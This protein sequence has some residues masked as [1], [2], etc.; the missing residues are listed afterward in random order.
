MA[1]DVPGL[2][3]PTLDPGPTPACASHP[4]EQTLYKG[5]AQGHRET[6]LKA[7]SGDPGPSLSSWPLGTRETP[8]RESWQ[9]RQRCGNPRVWTGKWGEVW[10]AE[11][12]TKARGQGSEGTRPRRPRWWHG[13]GQKEVTER[14]PSPCG[15]KARAGPPGMGGQTPS[16]SRGTNGDPGHKTPGEFDFFKKRQGQRDAALPFKMLIWRVSCLWEQSEDLQGKTLYEGRQNH[17]WSD[18]VQTGQPRGKTFHPCHTAHGHR[19][20]H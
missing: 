8:Q 19:R 5:K 10:P 1:P 13:T 17:Q 6:F 4:P 11:Q 7:L 2:G 9:P 20:G 15:I 18:E 16:R 12:R 14:A 3:H